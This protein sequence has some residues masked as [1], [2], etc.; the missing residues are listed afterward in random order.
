MGVI[1]GCTTGYN[2]YATNGSLRIAVACCSALCD[3]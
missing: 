3:M 1:T 2:F